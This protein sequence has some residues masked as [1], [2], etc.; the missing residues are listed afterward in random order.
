MPACR[1]L[2]ALLLDE[3][4]AA[5]RQHFEDRLT[6]VAVFLWVVCKEAEQQQRKK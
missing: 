6:M 3:S 4:E 1:V 2:A 5:Q